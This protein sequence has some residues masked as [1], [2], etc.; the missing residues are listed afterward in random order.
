[1]CLNEKINSG[2]IDEYQL[3]KLTKIIDEYTIR[4]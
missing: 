4:R 1:L 2:I 3:E